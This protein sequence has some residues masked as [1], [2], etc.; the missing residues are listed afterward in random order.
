MKKYL[1]IFICV[2]LILSFTS[3]SYAFPFSTIPNE[4]VEKTENLLIQIEPYKELY[5]LDNID[6]STLKLSE[7]I[8]TFE[9]KNDLINEL[10]FKCIPLR[11]A[12]G[13]IVGL[14]IAYQ[15]SAGNINVEFT[16]DFV[17]QMN[18]MNDAFALVYTAT[19][20]I[21]ID[22]V[23]TMDSLS[24]T[25]RTGS[26]ATDDRLVYVSMTSG[27]SYYFEDCLRRDFE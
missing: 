1:I 17:D 12:S 11:D 23:S 7:E 19:G 27:N 16:T 18:D 22:N 13:E 3:V 26:V 10:N 25:Y 24:G 21:L 15:E 5:G 8:P 4:I 2:M 6:F 9:L 20:P 14:I